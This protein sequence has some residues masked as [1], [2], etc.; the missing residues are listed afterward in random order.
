MSLYAAIHAREFP[1]QAL[2]RLRPELRHQPC[3]VLEGE[4]PLQSVCA[5]NSRARRMGIE[6]GMT[7]VE[8]DTFPDVTI[9][10][11]SAVEEASARAAL[12]DCASI[13]SPAAEDLSS[14]TAF[15]AV[16]DITG[17]DRLH[18]PPA[19]LA[20]ALHERISAV[21]I[22]A[23]IAVAQNFHAAVCL[24]R[25]LHTTRHPL[26]IQPGEESSA[27]DPLPISTLNFTPGFTPDHAETFAAWGIHT[28]GDLAALPETALIARMGQP[29]R[30]LR[31]LALGTHPHHFTPIDPAPTYTETLEF[32]APIEQLES[33]LFVLGAML[34][35]LILRISSRALA[36]ATITVTLSLEPSGTCTR[37]I[38]PALPVN[39]KHLW[40]KL[41]HL[42]LEAHPPGAPVLTLTLTAEPGRTS[43]IQIGLFSPQLP[44]STRL[45]VALAR[46]RA[47]IGED[48]VGSPILTDT[49]QPD[50]FQI[51]PFSVTNETK[52]YAAPPNAPVRSTRV[53]NPTTDLS[54]RPEPRS[55][56][57]EKPASAPATA[58]P[59][60]QRQL[61]P[62]EELF[63]T[64]QNHQPATFYFRQKKYAVT[65]AYGPWLAAGD[66]WNQTLWGIEQW[67]V[68]ARSA[69]GTLLCCCLTRDLLHNR[70][71][72]VALYD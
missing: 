8:V 14:S 6:P 21:R 52:R 31:Q 47:L 55:G 68:V 20:A 72:M 16:L 30:M 57:V 5:R 58:A 53:D 44:D 33:L 9:L 65:R 61:R 45:D 26:I 2:L 29:G 4:P 69:E 37:I 32:D 71:H 34:D 25:G 38:Q 64:I 54:F 50:A 12:F 7:R 60:T 18:G 19:T 35:Q 3:V 56:V 43:K 41:I 39:D 22:S 36:L 28:L 27:L 59:L 17:T 24:A 15:I 49:H 46:I 66:W 62:A 1:A 13:F 70:W 63:V 40:L 51:Q 42:D 48:R 67:D 11:R 10:R 23:S